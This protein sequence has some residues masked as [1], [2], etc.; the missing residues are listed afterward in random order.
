[1]PVPEFLKNPEK[2]SS[3]VHALHQMKN[4]LVIP[5]VRLDRAI[6]IVIEKVDSIAVQNHPVFNPHCSQSSSICGSRAVSL[7]W[8]GKPIDPSASVSL[9]VVMAPGMGVPENRS[10]W[11]APTRGCWA[12]FEAVGSGIHERNCSGIAPNTYGGTYLYD[13]HLTVWKHEPSLLLCIVTVRLP[14][15]LVFRKFTFPPPFAQCTCIAVYGRL[16]GIAAFRWRLSYRAL[17]ERPTIVFTFNGIC[18]K[19]TRVQVKHHKGS[20]FGGKQFGSGSQ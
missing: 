4:C 15:G 19:K 20:G 9:I 16:A 13:L 1:V 2:L 17:F 3:I 18:S 7:G 12:K 11:P 6:V 5:I 14:K 8:P 10:I